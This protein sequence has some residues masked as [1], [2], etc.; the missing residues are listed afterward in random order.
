[1]P[2]TLIKFGRTTNLQDYNSE[3]VDAEYQLGEGECPEK[4]MSK[5]K[6][7]VNTGK[8]REEEVAEEKPVKKA[9]K[10][11][12]KKVEEPKEEE[13]VEEKVEEKPEKKVTKKKVTKKKPAEKKPKVTTYD[14]ELANKPHQK[15]LA[16][17][18]RTHDPEWKKNHKEECQEFSKNMQGKDFLDHKGNILESVKEEIAGLFEEL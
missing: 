9:T 12:S 16:A 1:M 10:K 8:F 3:R 4:A 17:E 14:R 18:F 7:F 13:V 6:D 2:I 15:L 5:L 11:V